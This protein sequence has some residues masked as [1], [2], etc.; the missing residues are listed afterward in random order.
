MRAER[1]TILQGSR[2]CFRARDEDGRLLFDVLSVALGQDAPFD[3]P[4][5]E[6]DRC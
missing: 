2:D 6:K 4:Q 3:V 5:A 1:E